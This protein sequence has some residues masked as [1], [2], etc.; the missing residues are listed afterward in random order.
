[1]PSAVGL[2]LILL[3]FIL[4]LQIYR[5]VP[6]VEQDA[7]DVSE[8]HKVNYKALGLAV[9]ASALPLLTMKPLGFVVT[10]TGCFMLVAA[11]FKSRRWLL[12][13]VLGLGF[14]L[15]CWWLF[16]KL[17]VQLGG[18]LPMMGV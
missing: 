12:D 9:I 14:S 10:C 7:E 4:S 17:G 11:A 2:A 6:F 1:M 5:G 8:N 16:R 3:G 15:L 13:F 18:L